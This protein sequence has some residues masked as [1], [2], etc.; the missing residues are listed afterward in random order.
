MSAFYGAGAGYRAAMSMQEN[1]VLNEFMENNA[2]SRAQAFHPVFSDLSMERWFY[3]ALERLVKKG[4]LVEAEHGKYYVSEAEL[5][6]QAQWKKYRWLIVPAMI[7]GWIIL[8]ILVFGN[9]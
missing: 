7:I 9:R 3:P 2:L 1:R 5:K 6:A 4:R 8:L